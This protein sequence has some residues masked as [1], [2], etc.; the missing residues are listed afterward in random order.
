MERERSDEA[1]R[2]AR[3]SGEQVDAEKRWRLSGRGPRGRSGRLA[4][5]LEIPED[6]R[7]TAIWKRVLLLQLIYSLVGLFLGGA[8]VLGGLFLF[9]SGIAAGTSTFSA[10]LFGS[11][12]GLTDAAP[13]AILFVVG[14][15]VVVATRF[16]VR[17]AVK[18]KGK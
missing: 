10:R 3:G 11:E 1:T 15:L 18:R 12:V 17:I 5:N 16:T 14:L 6:I 8:C 4:W 9:V 7:S 13:G 2:E